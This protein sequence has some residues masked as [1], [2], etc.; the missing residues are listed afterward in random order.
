MQL[1]D[2]PGIIEGAKDGKGRGRQIIS[3]AR[4]C[5]VLLIV[6]D[7]LKPLTHRRK[8]EKELA[9]FGI[10]LNKK[11]PKITVT[12]KERGGITY[13]HYNLSLSPMI[14][15]MSTPFLLSYFSD[16]HAKIRVWIS[17]RSHQF[18]RS[19]RCTTRT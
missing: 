14:R 4:T 7:V 16:I 11:P 13:V 3:T 18:V 1:L 9:G 5:N 6:L 15:T 12:K 10:R 17:R 8:I 19:T 2:L